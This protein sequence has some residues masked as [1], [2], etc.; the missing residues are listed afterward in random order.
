MLQDPVIKRLSLE[1]NSE[2]NVIFGTDAI[3]SLLMCSPR[4]HY[5]WDVLVRR[6]GGKMLFFDKRDK[7][8]FGV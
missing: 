3:L 6:V 8:Q 4:T 1:N 7:S 5:S 2:G